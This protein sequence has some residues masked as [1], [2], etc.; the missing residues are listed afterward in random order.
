M[1]PRYELNAR[2]QSQSTFLLLIKEKLQEHSPICIQLNDTKVILP[3]KNEAISKI[4]NFINTMTVP[5]IIFCDFEFLLNDHREDFM[6]NPP[7]GA[8]EQHKVI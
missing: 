6:E 3:A 1:R 7:I 4:K 2:K 8:Y 5:F